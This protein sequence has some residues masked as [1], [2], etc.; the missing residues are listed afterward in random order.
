LRTGSA[1]TSTLD[2]EHVA[3]PFA[4]HGKLAEISKAAASH[5]V[6]ETHQHIDV[7]SRSGI[8]TGD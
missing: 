1:T 5:A 6:V 4:E 7:R 8:V 2:A 3:H